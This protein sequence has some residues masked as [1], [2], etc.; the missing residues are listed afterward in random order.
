MK[1]HIKKT[2][3]SLEVRNYR[4]YFIGQAIYLSGTW[5]QTIGQAWLVLKLTNSG[6]ALGIK[7]ALQFLPILLLG[8]IGGVAADRFPKRKILYATQ[9]I[10]AILALI[11]GILVAT[12][13]AAVWMVGVLAFLFGLVTVFDN[14]ARQ[15]F[16]FEMVGQERLFN[17]V[18]LNTAEINLAR[19]VGP[20]LGGGLIVF[21][22][23][24]PLFILNGFSY[25]AV[26]IMLFFMNDK[27]L[28]SL[29]RPNSSK[30]Q[31][32]RGFSYVFST[33]ILR[34]T[35]LMMAIIGTFAYEFN[36]ILP[37]LAEFTFH[38]N[39]ATFAALTAA[40][41]AGS[42][43]GAFFT[44]GRARTGAPILIINAF[45]LGLFLLITAVSPSFIFACFAL[46]LVG[47]A[48]I[49][50]ISAGNTT[51]QLESKPEM[52]GIVMSLWTV[53]FLGSTPIGGPIIGWIGEFIGPR[54]G[55]AT[56][57]AAAILAS[58]YGAAV[59]LKGNRI[60]TITKSIWIESSQSANQELRVK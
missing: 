3:L 12:N 56:G 31:I 47:I 13:T 32:R 48:S 52:R 22:G 27:E 41:G 26:L 50:F 17:A 6:T 10:Y 33:P 38:G 45:L 39:A 25:C 36:V 24:A 8:P 44:A 43:I 40:M 60:E 29:R 7:T 49:N 18:T 54:M 16:V 20:S 55:L 15:V 19:V 28:H 35:L 11:L 1:Q 59:L 57:G 42:V 9:S 21:L 51:L 46:I 5:M 37:I 14:P 58:I 23:L 2:F 4:L 30:N 34:D 53:A